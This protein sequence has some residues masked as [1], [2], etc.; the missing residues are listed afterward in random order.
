MAQIMIQIQRLRYTI[1]GTYLQETVQF[2]LNITNKTNINKFSKLNFKKIIRLI[3]N[4]INIFNEKIKI[5]IHS[6]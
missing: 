6:A 5:L 1:N 2:M 4:F 3:L